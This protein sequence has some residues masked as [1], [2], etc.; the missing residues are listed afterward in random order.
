MTLVIIHCCA[1]RLGHLS[2]SAS[3]FVT[4]RTAMSTSLTVEQNNTFDFWE[5]ICCAHCHRPFQTDHN[6]APPVPFWLTECGHI[7]CNNDLSM[8]IL[9]RYMRVFA[10]SFDHVVVDSDQHC[11]ICGTRGIHLTALQRDVGRQRVIFMFMHT[12]PDIS[13]QLGSPMAVWFH[14]IPD[15]LESTIAALKVITDRSLRFPAPNDLLSSLV[16]TRAYGL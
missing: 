6:A 11:T 8:T 14:S 1:R 3:L 13:L 10:L 4:L 7:I 12:A 2:D 15:T 5:F 16:S 9:E